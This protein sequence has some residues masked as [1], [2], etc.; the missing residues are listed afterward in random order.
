MTKR[1]AAASIDALM[2]RTHKRTGG[3]VRITYSGTLF[4]AHAYPSREAANESVKRS[5]VKYGGDDRS[6]TADELSNLVNE[7]QA[8]A[9]AYGRGKS[10]EEALDQLGRALASLTSSK[11]DAP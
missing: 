5:M 7:A 8:H 4:Y 10:I 6:L 3:Q 11:G 2:R 1:K 9:L